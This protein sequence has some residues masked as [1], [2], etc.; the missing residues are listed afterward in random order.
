MVLTTVW[1]AL[2]KVPWYRA[3]PRKALTSGGMLSGSS[4]FTSRRYSRDTR[5]NCSFHS[6]GGAN[7]K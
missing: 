4:A 3:D 7:G 1:A 2:S 5:F 6:P